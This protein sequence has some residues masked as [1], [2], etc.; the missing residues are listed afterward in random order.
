[1]LFTQ[2]GE[3]GTKQLDCGSGSTA[4]RLSDRCLSR[5]NHSHKDE[6]VF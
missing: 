6:P 3:A 2:A 4:M 1:M 5:W